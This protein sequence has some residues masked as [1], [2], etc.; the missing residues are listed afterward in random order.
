MV[1]KKCPL[2]REVGFIEIFSKIVWPQSKAVRSSSHCP[3][4]ESDRFIVCPL[5]RT[6]WWEVFARFWEFI[7]LTLSWRR[8]ISYRNQ[9]IWYNGL[10]SIWYGLS[11]MK[12]LKYLVEIKRGLVIRQNFHL[13]IITFFCLRNKINM[14]KNSTALN[15][16]IYNAVKLLNSGHLGV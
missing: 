15:L 10:V 1:Q 11:V 4:Y 5:Y 7:Q 3:P 6:R 2:Y 8:P 16:F 9:S 12:R 14:S 13:I